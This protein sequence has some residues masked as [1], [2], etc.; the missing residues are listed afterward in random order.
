MHTCSCIFFECWIVNA[1][2]NAPVQVMCL[3]SSLP[4]VFVHSI[5]LKVNSALCVVIVTAFLK[6]TVICSYKWQARVHQRVKNDRG[7]PQCSRK[8]CLGSPQPTFK[9]AQH[10]LLLEWDHERNPKLGIHPHNTTLGSKKKVHWVCRS[11]PEGRLHLYQMMPNSR[12]GK[13][14]RSCPYCAGRQVCKCNCLETLY[15]VTSSE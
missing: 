14:K 8:L 1:G 7:C 11:C 13:Q 12:C 15:P 10:P 3:L 4:Q 5:L 2:S 6:T 9:A